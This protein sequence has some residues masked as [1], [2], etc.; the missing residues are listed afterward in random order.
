MSITE[1]LT[2]RSSESKKLA[3]NYSKVQVTVEGI[4]RAAD[5][6][7][8]TKTNFVSIIDEINKMK[9]V[10]DYFSA[11]LPVEEYEDSFDELIKHVRGLGTTLQ[12]NANAVKAYEDSSGL[13]KFAA[14]LGMA[15]AKTG[16]GFVS[17]FEDLGD[18][19]VSLGGFVA[20]NTVGR[21]TGTKEGMEEFVGNIVKKDISHD[22]FDFLYYSRDIAK[23][24]AFTEDSGLAGAFNVVGKSA[25]YL[26]MGGA[27][28][29]VGGKL[30]LIGKE[31]FVGKVLGKAASSTTW[32]A[33]A[34]AGIG[35]TGSGTEASL[36]RGNDFNQ[37]FKDGAVQGA[38]QAG[39]AFGAGAAS[40]KIQ[41]HKLLKS[42]DP[43]DILQAGQNVQGYNDPITRAGQKFG[44]HPKDTVIGAAKNAANTVLHPVNNILKPA[45]NTVLHPVNNILK[46]AAKSVVTAAS[47]VATNPG[48]AT[49]T[50]E[51]V[52][53]V[54]NEM[55][56]RKK[57]NPLPNSDI[58]PATPDGNISVTS[59]PTVENANNN[60]DNTSVPQQSSQPPENNNNHP[61]ENNNNHPN[62]NNNNYPSENNNNHPSGGGDGGDSIS[63]PSYSDTIPSNTTPTETIPTTTT[64][65]TNTDTT[66]SN[67][68]PI[69]SAE[70][71]NEATTTEEVL[72]SDTTTNTTN[73]NTPG[74][75]DTSV[76]TPS[77]TSSNTTQNTV[78]EPAT[79]T[80]TEQQS[81]PET[82]SQETFSAPSTT[83]Y[84]GGSYSEDTGYIST[85]EENGIEEM[86]N[87][88][89]E[90]TDETA[91][92]DDASDSIEDIIQKGRTTKIPTSSVPIQPTV[93]NKGNSVIPIAAGL[94][95]AAAAGIGAKAYID[96]KNNSS[97]NDIDAEE[98]SE[99]DDLLEID[100]SSENESEELS[101]EDEYSYQ[102]ETEKYGARNNEELADLQ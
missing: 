27:L 52:F 69:S 72:N 32:G 101:S 100:E 49:T 47:T 79:T 92:I 23:K 80:P 62:E 7:E 5:E 71:S 30:P 77:D 89:L 58:S 74:T 28:S 61:N 53:R 76:A 75:K 48:V 102:E 60:T 55:D 88:D 70:P 2:G 31:K 68:D 12:S 78:P 42:D 83:H 65:T 38:V 16:E 97:Y 87:I 67:I 18:G 98:W 44:A 10:A 99:D 93:K 64:P 91:L 15:A 35:G 85:N 20:A 14:T 59:N 33:T 13:E 3:T 95:A 25:G 21:L 45:A 36:I 94:S 34:A 50:A 1:F 6:I 29:E 19:V 84:T 43:A 4:N 26:Y 9:G 57:Q 24:S 8:T 73:N 82:A 86:T 96:H 81:P 41:Q 37:A 40:E 11:T 66:N 90:P 56:A 22:V 17:A 54:S 51:N 46:P 39:L 63:S